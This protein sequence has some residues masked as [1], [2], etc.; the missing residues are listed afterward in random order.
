M[1]V[2]SGDGG[3][4]KTALL[5]SICLQARQQG[6]DVGIG[7]AEESDQIVPLVPLLLALRSGRDPLLSRDAFAALAAIQHQ[8]LWVVDMV[9]DALETRAMQRP[10]VICIDDLQWADQSSLFALGVLT[11]R[12]A[13]SPIVWLIATRPGTKAAEDIAETASRDMPVARVSLQPLSSEAIEQLATDRLGDAVDSDVRHVLAGADGVPFLAVALLEGLAA[14]LPLGVGSRSGSSALNAGALPDSLVL[15]VRARLESLPAQSVRLV[16]IGA[17]L[18]RSFTVTDASALLGAPSADSVLPWVEPAVRA[19]VLEDTGENIAFRHDLLRQA[20]YAD[21][22]ASVRRALHRAA[23]AQMLTGGRGPLEAAPHILRSATTGDFEAASILRR[24]AT[25]AARNAPVTS[26]ELSQRALSLLRPDDDDWEEYGREA[27]LR[28]NTAGRG[29]DA[30][31]VADQLLNSGLTHELAAQVQI[32]VAHSMWTRG[33]LDQM[34]S[35]VAVAVEL[36]DVA[37]GTHGHLLALRALA[38]SRDDDAGDAIH[39]AEQALIQGEDSQDAAT[40]TTALHALGEIARNDGRNDDALSFFR[41]MRGVSGRE[42]FHEEVLSL[43]LLDRF[44]ESAAMLGAAENRANAAGWSAYPPDVSFGLMWQAFS[45]GSLDDSETHALSVMRVGDELKQY[46]FHSEARVVLSRVAQLRG[47]LNRAH[48]QLSQAIRHANHDNARSLTLTVMRAWLSRAEGNDVDALEAVHI[49]MRAKPPIR[50]RWL[51]QPGWLLPAVQIAAHAGDRELASHIASL[52]ESLHQHNPTVATNA[53]VAACAKGLAT[54]N[55][56][57]L[58]DALRLCLPSPR[59]LIRAQITSLLG[60]ALL[61]EQTTASGV[62]A[63]DDAWDLYTRLGAHGEARQ[64]QQILQNAGVRR[65][66]WTLAG[67]RPVTGWAALTVSERRVARLI[68]EG[69]TNRSAAEV[70][71]LSTNTIATHLRSVYSK[72][73]VQSRVQLSLAVAA[74]DGPESKP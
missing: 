6:Y 64:I 44:E 50:H 14:R 74:L 54:A 20:V 28:L 23:A 69:H 57:L 70:L 52:A 8:P 25:A 40:Q 60:Q 68:A 21:T 53:A 36:P 65:R 43:Q 30:M 32:E 56:E 51:W 49:L 61:H 29:N 71:V 55:T 34:L 3:M 24:A 33:E 17:V 58:A 66:R 62:T 1:V 46:S 45:L 27:L 67:A 39:D 38:H 47:D 48:D 22:P 7:K 63:L 11:G 37:S 35:R 26:A 12:L 5:R 9:V 73:D 19:G 13:A 72:L 10:V 31:D 41:S 16:R 15:G 2:V 42:Y 18:G 4:G 59:L